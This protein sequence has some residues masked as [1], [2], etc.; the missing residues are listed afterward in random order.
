VAKQ[1][2]AVSR[3]ELIAECWD[4]ILPPE[5]NVLDV[6][7]IQLRRKLLDPPMIHTVR[8]IGYRID[9]A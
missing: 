8:A 3:D 5:S 1:G 2:S 4:R 7:L 6:V 9:P